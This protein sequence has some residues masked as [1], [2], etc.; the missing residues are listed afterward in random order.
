MRAIFSGGGTGGHLYPAL[1]IIEYMRNKGI[2]SDVKYV[3]GYGIENRVV[4]DYGI[5]YFGFNIK[6]LKRPK[7]SPSNLKVI[8]QYYVA[9]SKIKKIIK[10][11]KPDFVFVTGGYASIPLVIAARKLKI[12]IFNQEQ[13]VYVGFANRFI[14]KFSL[15]TFT[16]FD[17]SINYFPKKDNV[18]VCGNPVMRK[19]IDRTMALKKFG[20]DNKITIGIFGGS[21]GSEKINDSIKAIYEKDDS[22]N[23]IHITGK[24]DYNRFRSID[25]RDNV[26]ILDYCKDMDSFYSACDIVISRAGA[27]TISELMT[28]K[29]PAILIPHPF[30]AENHQL[31]NAEYLQKQGFAMVIEDDKLNSDILK[32]YID[33]M[34]TEI[35]EIR[36]RYEKIEIRNSLE[37]INNKILEV[38]NERKNN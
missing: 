19:K 5:E 18:V 13:N 38:L 2:L 3:G 8:L 6:G 11:F 27:M 7:K 23:Y 32:N 22:N 26:K 37:T 14:N 15:V 30:A 12:P 24:R 4:P 35:G 10:D 9:A 1:A 20:L 17:R 31:Y 16:N 34:I 29:I 25:N 36:K 21:G 28:L 33:E